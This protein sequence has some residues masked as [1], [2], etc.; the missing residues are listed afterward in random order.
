MW[1]IDQFGLKYDREFALVS[2]KTQKT[3]TQVMNMKMSQILP[4]IDLE[5]RIISVEAPGMPKMSFPIDF[6]DSKDCV[7]KLCGV[8]CD[9]LALKDGKG[10]E[11]INEW[12]T[13]FLEE[14]CMLVKANGGTLFLISP[15]S[16]IH[17]FI[18]IF[19]LFRNRQLYKPLAFL[20]GF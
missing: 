10:S 9:A 19:R 14:P 1:K 12:F 17:T 4:S 2:K 6:S 20:V 5:Q 8:N 7:V 3:I 18:S 13:T 11:K 16:V 15:L